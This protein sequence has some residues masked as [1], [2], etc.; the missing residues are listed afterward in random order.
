MDQVINVLYSIL[1]LVAISAGVFVFLLN[2]WVTIHIL[3]NKN[4]TRGAIGWIGLTW[5]SP[6]F[7]AILYFLFGINR[8]QRKARRTYGEADFPDVETVTS[9]VICTIDDL[10]KTL[11]HPNLLSLSRVVDRTS[12]QKRTRG[13][14]I[15][16]LVNGEE[17][18]PAMIEAIENAEQSITLLTFIFQ[19][20]QVG[21]RFFEALRDA[22]E[23]GVEV[24]VLIDDVGARYSF[25]T[26]PGKF[27]KAGIPV[28]RFMETWFPW[29]FRY[30][31]LRNHRKIMVVDGS[32]GFTGGMNISE[33]YM[34]DEHA[35]SY[36]DLHFRL[37]G[38]VVQQLQETFIYDWEFAE[39]EKLKGEPWFVDETIEGDVPARGIADGPDE[40]FNALQTTFLGALS[41]A[42]ESVRIITPYFLP[43]AEL[44]GALN[45]AALK[46]VDVKIIL[47]EVNNPKLVHWASMATLE[48]ILEY[49]CEVY[50]TPE[51]FD[52]SK[53]VLVDKEWVCLGSTNWDPRSL[54]L[55][56]EFNVECYSSDLGARVNELMEDH[57]EAG[58]KL[59]L[60]DLRNRGLPAQLRDRFFRLFTPYL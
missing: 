42:T 47:P 25:P 35:S 52:H 59:S 9:N 14:R 39:G 34:R 38:P 4:D 40:S 22:H 36:R 27:K 48:H 3:F 33:Q 5:F 29:R 41:C 10:E 44:I 17:A 55:N 31:N 7:G 23:R 46:G 12:D 15:E 45:V 13:N 37:E 51:P 8:I 24:R 18:Y 32:I 30:L 50:L 2:S 49:D 19:N 53:L 26:I 43:E 56:F 58:R 54:K 57:L 28:A 20:D 11:D 16:P 6:G 1:N 21:N 60:E